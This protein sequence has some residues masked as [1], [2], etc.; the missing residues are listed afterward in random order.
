[1]A[2]KV[3]IADIAER[4]GVSRATVSRVLNNF[5][6]ISA[7]KRQLV[8]RAMEELNYKPS[9]VAR[10][11]RTQKSK[12]IGFLT[13]EVA[14]TPYAGDIIK[15]AEEA[16]WK[17]DY[18]MLVMSAGHENHRVDAAVDAM[19]ER[20]V[21][22]II[23]AAMYH[24][25]VKLPENIFS[26]PVVL[27]N[28]YDPQSRVP[29]VVPN[30][31]LGGYQATEALLKNGHRRIGFINIYQ[32]N[33]GIPASRGRQLGYQQALTDHNISFDETFVRNGQGTPDDGYMYAHELLNLAMPPTAIF[34][35]NDRTAMGAYDAL[36]ER[37][38]KIPDDV[39]IIG[40][41]NQEIIAAS[42]RPSLSTMQLPHYEMGQWAMQKL[43][44]TDFDNESSAGYYQQHKLICE[45]VERNSV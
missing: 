22:G 13:D 16:A 25:P 19:L 7:D 11:M 32:V 28:C 29:A 20:E 34:C 2:K 24:R 4:A 33:D 35:G 23:Y 37:G 10:H 38:L 42:L 12:M 18:T 45:F 44:N 17:H 14:T 9:L 41:D 5:D 36:R 30:E 21:E 26:V 31:E 15:G 6:Y 3:T 39:A 1:M 40:F 43:I 8:E 27:A